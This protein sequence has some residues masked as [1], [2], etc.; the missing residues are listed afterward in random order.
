M[1]LSCSKLTHLLLLLHHISVTVQVPTGEV[2]GPSALLVSRP[3]TSQLLA[4]AVTATL[5]SG[6]K[7]CRG[8]VL[9]ERDAERQMAE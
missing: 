7:Q 6:E 1:G 4:A 9:G 8:R 3:Q 2:G 5:L